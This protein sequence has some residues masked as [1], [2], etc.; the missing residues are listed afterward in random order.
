MPGGSQ[1]SYTTRAIR[2]KFS[3][4][5]ANALRFFRFYPY[6]SLNG[7]LVIPFILHSAY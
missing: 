4:A 7:N 5:P 6:F 1:M 3:L 2:C